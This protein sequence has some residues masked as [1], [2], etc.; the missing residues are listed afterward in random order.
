MSELKKINFDD[1]ESFIDILISNKDYVY[2]CIFYSC[3]LL[4]GTFFYSNID[5]DLI[6]KVIEAL[7][8]A[9]SQ[10]LQL[11]I[12][13]FCVYFSI[14]VI[15]V[16]LGMCLIGFPFVNIVPLVIGI[17]AGIKISYYYVVYG[18][19]GVG[20]SVLMIVPEITALITVLVFTIKNSNELSKMI[21]DAATKKSDMTDEVNLKS[22]LKSFLIYGLIVLVISALNALVEFLLQSIIKI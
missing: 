18:A 6:K 5:T 13:R 7:S 10:Y 20:Y 9:S 17:E 14:F 3:G 1:R 4:I 22:Y 11:F 8:S 19:K 21:Y 12:N 16:L 15:V 2:P